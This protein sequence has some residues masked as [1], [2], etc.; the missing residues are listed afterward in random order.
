MRLLQCPQLA[1]EAL[2]V[3]VCVQTMEM[4]LQRFKVAVKRLLGLIRAIGAKETK[5][6]DDPQTS[7]RKVG[8]PH[9]SQLTVSLCVCVHRLVFIHGI[10]FLFLWYCLSTRNN[11]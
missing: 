5:H 3:C 8:T 9:S 6:P 7:A 11:S 10:E 4:F 2:R 1:L